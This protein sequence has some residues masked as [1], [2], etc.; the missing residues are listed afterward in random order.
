[1]TAGE[2]EFQLVAERGED[3]RRGDEGGSAAPVQWTLSVVLGGSSKACRWVEANGWNS[4]RGW[5]KGE[6]GQGETLAVR[7]RLGIR[8]K[9]KQS[10]SPFSGSCVARW[11]RKQSQF[12]EGK[13]T[14]RLEFLRWTKVHTVSRRGS[15]VPI[16]R[17]RAGGI[18]EPEETLWKGLL[19]GAVEGERG[20][21]AWRRS[22]GSQSGRFWRTS[23]KK[24]SRK[25]STIGI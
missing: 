22:L 14:A 15:T 23:P 12:G 16:Q 20:G 13:L 3:A 1:M 6:E 9:L 8:A 2:G 18:L 19:W 7:I 25:V 4:P 24:Q 17:E 21:G 11:F 10:A 5:W